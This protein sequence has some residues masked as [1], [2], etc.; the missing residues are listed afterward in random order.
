MVALEI[1][2]WRGLTGSQLYFDQFF[3]SSFAEGRGSETS[4]TCGEAAESSGQEETGST[5][6]WAVISSEKEQTSPP[7]VQLWPRERSQSLSAPWEKEEI[8]EGPQTGRR[9]CVGR[10]DSGCW[11]MV[12]RSGLFV[13]RD[14]W[15][16]LTPLWLLSCWALGCCL[17]SSLGVRRDWPSGRE[18]GFWS[19]AD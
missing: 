10:G 16:V 17:L 5:Y 14:L 7:P 12:C 15:F 18:S 13:L 11:P 2:A 3:F 1:A 19:W 4:G 6:Q 8:T 9:A